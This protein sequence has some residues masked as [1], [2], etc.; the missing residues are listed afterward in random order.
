MLCHAIELALKA[1]LA[2]LGATPERLKYDF[3]HKLDELVNEAVGKGLP[4]TTKTQDGIKALNKA[5]TE[6]R[7]RYP[8]EGPV[9]APAARELL[10]AVS[11]EVHGAPLSEL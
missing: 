4:L 1:F 5:R 6:F 7:H 9:Y 8:G 10:N 3:G 2:K 11:R